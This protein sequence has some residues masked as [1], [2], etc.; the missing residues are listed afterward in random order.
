MDKSMNDRILN[1]VFIVMVGLTFF[2]L[3]KNMIWLSCILTVM[4]LFFIGVL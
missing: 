3:F 2:S 1:A 4:F